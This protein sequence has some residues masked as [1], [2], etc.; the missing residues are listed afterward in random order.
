MSS[1]TVA[2][3]PL[4]PLV[5][6]LLSGLGEDPDRPGLVRTPE[7]V[8]ASLRWLTRGYSLTV[9]DAVGGALFEEAHESMILVRDI[10]FYSLCEHHLLPFYGRCHIGYIP[11]AASSA[12][13]SWPAWSTCSAEGSRSRSA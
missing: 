4:A 11:R 2:D 6:G 7:R 10:E 8:E 5:R 9:R 3:A 1:T 12:S 13:A